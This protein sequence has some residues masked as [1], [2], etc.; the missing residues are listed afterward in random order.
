VGFIGGSNVCATSNHDFDCFNAGASAPYPSPLAAGV[1]RDPG[2]LGDVYPGTG[3][4][5]GA[6]AGTWRALISYDRALSERLSLGGRLGYAFG[7][8]PP[9]PEG[10]RFL[11]V[12]AEARL[13]YWLRDIGASGVRPYLHVGGG[14]AQVDL[15][16]SDVT[17]RDCSE[18]PARD[19]FLACIDARDAYDSANHPELPQKRLDAY[20]KLGNAFVTT[21]A[22]A[23]VGLTGNTGLQVHLNAMLMLPSVGV[24]IEPSLGMVF[25]F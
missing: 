4:G 21:G 1:A 24:V 2:E 14:I 16:K 18:E 10:R 6:S 11:P 5:M 7:G 13:S 22:G 20:R 17:V 25:G 23:V 15:K 8:G 12:H 3:I 9:T 19:A